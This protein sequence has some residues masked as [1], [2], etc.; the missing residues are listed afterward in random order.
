[1]AEWLR[2]ALPR[3][4]F[5]AGLG[6]LSLSSLSGAK[7]TRELNTGDFTSV[8]SPDQKFCLCN[9]VNNA[10]STKTGSISLRLL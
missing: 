2:S 4:P 7:L 3:H 10:M 8:S 1:M 6:R 5:R 9:S